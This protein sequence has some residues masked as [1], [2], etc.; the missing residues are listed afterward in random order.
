MTSNLR[1]T[2]SAGITALLRQAQI[3]A[4]EWVS[5]T[6]ASAQTLELLAHEV[7]RVVV[8]QA[9]LGLWD[10]YI[11]PQDPADPQT[12][13]E[14]SR[15]GALKVDVVFGNTLVGE[16]PLK[17]EYDFSRTS[18]PMLVVKSQKKAA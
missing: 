7:R 11:P 5:G 3:T 8:R 10:D 15:F 4:L 14:R 1:I 2:P 9:M 17:V 18:L 6:D 16:P 13:L 12:S